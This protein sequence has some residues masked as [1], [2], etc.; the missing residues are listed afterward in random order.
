MPGAP[1]FPVLVL[2]STDEA[3]SLL[4]SVRVEPIVAG[5]T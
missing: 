4:G 3:K 5:I 1:T 2:T